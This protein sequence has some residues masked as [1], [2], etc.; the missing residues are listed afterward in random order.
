MATL[1]QIKRRIR[2][3]GRASARSIG[4]GLGPHRGLKSGAWIVGAAHFNARGWR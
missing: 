3:D 1:R 2:P 4:N